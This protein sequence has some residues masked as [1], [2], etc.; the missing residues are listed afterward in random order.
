MI[1]VGIDVGTTG[2]KA[3]ALDGDG[4]LLRE[5]AERYPTRLEGTGAE[6]DA[7]A[8]WRAACAALPH[9]V[10]GEPVRGVAVTCQAPTLVGVDRTGTPTG[11][12]LTWIDRRA[13]AEAGEIDRLLTSATRNPVDPFFGT[14][15]LLWA[16]RRSGYL[17]GA[18]SV[19]GANGFVV[20][21]L[22]GTSS[23]DDST[24]GMLQGWDDGFPAELT[25]AGVPVDLLPRAV[26]G[27]Q[28]VGE[29]TPEAARASGLPPGTPV[30]AGGIDAVG[31]AL[32]AG[33]FAPDDAPVEMT[34]FSTVTIRA[35][36][37]GAH[38]PGMIH[39]RHC[40]PDTDLVLSAQNTTGS[41]VEWLRRTTGIDPTS[42]GTLPVRRPGRL[43]M[44]PSFAGDRTP[45]WS[46]SARGALVGLDLDC[47][48]GD[49]LLAL[50]E[51]TALAL[52]EC[53]ERMYPPGTGVRLL[54]C[55][56]GGANSSDWLQ[57]KADVLGCSVDVPENGHGAAVG[58]GL[59]AG[60]ATGH[61]GGVAE[62]RPRAESAR[63]RF[64]PDTDRHAAYTDRLASFVALRD[65]VEPYSSE[66][67]AA[68][69]A[70]NEEGEQ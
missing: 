67:V 21:R 60:L 17:D 26:G 28:V 2:L 23:L 20:R 29:V 4:R 62:L 53:L 49:L 66:L 27:Q 42:A 68:V 45:T 55:L 12:A 43:L 35:A 59:L 52:R 38:V 8:W 32:E 37:R 47:A 5:R 1:L 14:G 63:A 54:R 61:F 19:L 57:I 34:G 65:A 31:A 36:S 40:L 30:A 7:E 51:G 64:V 46:T 39:T 44:V 69:P 13:A 56:G 15:K 3:V 25:A 6:Q 50:Y 33:A 18:E 58:A 22:T 11:P 9:V 16:S 10:A 41:V 70:P 48:P 24:A